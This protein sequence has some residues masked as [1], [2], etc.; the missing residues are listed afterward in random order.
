MLWTLVWATCSQIFIG[1]LGMKYPFIVCHACIQ[2]AIQPGHCSLLFGL[3]M[4]TRRDE[5][6]EELFETKTSS[7]K[8][9][10]AV[11]K[12][13]LSLFARQSTNKIRC[14]NAFV[15]GIGADRC[16]SDTAVARHCPSD[17]W[18]NEQ[19]QYGGVFRG[20]RM[21]R[22]CSWGTSEGVWRD[23]PRR[24]KDPSPKKTPCLA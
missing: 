24:C 10:P 4:P 19:L 6:G 11:A 7:S 5:E 9:K 12:R 20:T 8:P 18:P 2:P 13:V 1:I 23:Q 17:F 22:R 15:R 21:T 16:S 14:A 3:A